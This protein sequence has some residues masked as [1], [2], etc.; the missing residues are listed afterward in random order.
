M[1]SR[2]LEDK[3]QSLGLGFGLVFELSL[4][5]AVLLNESFNKALVLVLKKKSYLRVYDC[6]I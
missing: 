2:R 6:R 1:V 3:N 5:C 4:Q